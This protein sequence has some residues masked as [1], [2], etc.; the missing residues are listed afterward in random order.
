MDGWIVA[1]FALVFIMGM[2]ANRPNIT[3]NVA[4]VITASA[5][6]SGGSGGGSL[7]GTL[8]GLGAMTLIGLTVLNMVKDTADNMVRQPERVPVSVPT[9]IAT[10]VPATAIPV[11]TP[12]VAPVV[13]PERVPVP[14]QQPIAVPMPDYTPLFVALALICLAQLGLALWYR[15]K[16]MAERQPNVWED[17]L[18][19]IDERKWREYE[20]AQR[21]SG[22]DKSFDKVL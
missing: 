10:A 18:T 21:Q 19:E 1:L 16:K 8:V 9:V 4:P 6:A 5:S 20:Q 22:Y 17:A 11:I 12:T 2:L 14:V 13:V 15:R 3:N 7:I